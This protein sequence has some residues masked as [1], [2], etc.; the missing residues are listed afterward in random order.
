MNTGLV[1]GIYGRI[2]R[3]TNSGDSWDSVGNPQTGFWYKM[4][5]INSNTGFI[6]LKVY[7]VNGKE[8]AN[9]I[10]EEMEPGYYSVNFDGSNIGSGV[11]FYRI[12]SEGFVQTKKML[13]IK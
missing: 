1:C 12:E 10:S 13:L 8:V 6:S 5:F 9:L 4:S 7:D 11:Y 2:F 3:T